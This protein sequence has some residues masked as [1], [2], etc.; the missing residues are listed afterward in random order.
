M[1]QLGYHGTNFYEILWW[2]ILLKYALTK[3]TPFF[4]NLNPYRHS[5]FC[6]NIVFHLFLALPKCLFF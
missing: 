5:V 2:R 4:S 1:E 6:A 3:L